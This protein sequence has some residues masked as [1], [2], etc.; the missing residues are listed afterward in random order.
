MDLIHPQNADF[1]LSHAA[2]VKAHIKGHV[3]DGELLY[4]GINIF[5][6]YRLR[7]WTFVGQHLNLAEKIVAH[8][9]ILGP[10]DHRSEAEDFKIDFSAFP[11]RLFKTFL[12][13]SFD[14]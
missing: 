6:A 4:Y 12:D 1:I 7:Q 13:E 9:H 10:S 8:P 14:E 3:S 2:E 11:G 5:P